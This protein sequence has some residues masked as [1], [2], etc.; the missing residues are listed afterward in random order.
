[1]HKALGIAMLVLSLCLSS[2]ADLAY[3]H[4][5]TFYGIDCRPE[6]LQNGQCVPVKKGTADTQTAPAVQQADTK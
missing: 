6:V 5:K 3:W 4:A 1:M 2:C